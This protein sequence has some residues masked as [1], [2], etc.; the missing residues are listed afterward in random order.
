MYIQPMLIALQLSK[1]VI[2]AGFDWYIVTLAVL[3]VPQLALTC[4]KG[5]RPVL[6]V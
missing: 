6:L 2:R 4:S 5:I 3:W 1:E